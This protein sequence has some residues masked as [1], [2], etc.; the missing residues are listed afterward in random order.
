MKTVIQSQDAPAAI[1]ICPRAL[2]AGTT[3]SLS[4]QTG[5]DPARAAFGVARLP[6]RVRAEID[7]IQHAG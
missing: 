5:L 6:R 7:A 1:G 2:R 3:V 4:G